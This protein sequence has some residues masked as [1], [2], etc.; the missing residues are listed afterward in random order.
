MYFRTTG[1]IQVLTSAPRHLTAAPSEVHPQAYVASESA[2]NLLT[3][4][5]QAY[6]EPNQS[7]SNLRVIADALATRVLTS[8]EG[9]VVAT[10]V[11]FLKN[12]TLQTI[13]ANR[14][15]I[16]CCGAFKTPQVLELSGEQ[17]LVASISHNLENFD[18]YR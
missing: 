2:L 16:L 1:L 12:G 10:G 11:E 5:P 7:R 13:H 4:F 17:C 14:E 18:R 9:L 3:K 8:R 15:V 6:Y